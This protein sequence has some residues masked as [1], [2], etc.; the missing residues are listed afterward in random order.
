MQ[1]HSLFVSQALHS[2]DNTLLEYC[3]GNHNPTIVSNTVQR[4]P[5][6]KVLPLLRTIVDKLR[7]RPARGAVLICWI[8]ELVLHHTAYL[9]S[10]PDLND[11]ACGRH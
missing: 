8:R 3:L 2:G 6:A 4:L 9:L 1:R 5:S 7:A 10:A 11:G